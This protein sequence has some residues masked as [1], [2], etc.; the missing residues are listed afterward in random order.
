MNVH[1]SEPARRQRLCAV[2][3]GAVQV[4]VFTAAM[5]TRL[6]AALALAA[7][8][9][10][11]GSAAVPAP[12]VLPQAVDVSEAAPP[13]SVP[14]LRS[15]C[16]VPADMPLA[17]LPAGIRPVKDVSFA[18]AAFQTANATALRAA[19]VVVGPH[20]DPGELARLD[21]FLPGLQNAA[22]AQTGS[23]EALAAQA[24]VTPLASC[25]GVFILPPV[26]RPTLLGWMQQATAVLNSSVAEGMPNAV[27]EAMA[28]GTPVVARRNEGTVA[29]LQALA[30][31]AAEGSGCCRGVLVDTGE[32]MVQAVQDAGAA[33]EAVQA[34]VQ[35]GKAAVAECFSAAAEQA[36]WA[37]ILES[38]L[39]PTPAAA[40]GGAAQLPAAE[41]DARQKYTPL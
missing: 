33:G 18:V 16:G 21:S 20:L 41:D 29:L 26:G 28:L 32:A 4:L 9:K 24:E 2:V 10:E 7:G 8:E 5:E 38:A 3:A 25:K 17:L 37:G 6:A 23:D 31:G 40:A 15:L 36:A 11:E 35:A 27:L 19:L 34:M 1:A 13:D 14:C 30:A 39:S 22:T 12:I